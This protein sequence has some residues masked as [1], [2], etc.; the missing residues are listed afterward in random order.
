M[1]SKPASQT[2]SQTKANSSVLQVVLL[3]FTLFYWLTGF[4]IENCSRRQTEA[5]SGLFAPQ[6]WWSARPGS[7][8]KTKPVS[9]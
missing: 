1:K 5:Y 2:Q 3:V 6:P 4:K 8:P 9:Q 7:Q